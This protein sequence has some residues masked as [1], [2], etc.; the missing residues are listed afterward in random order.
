MKRTITALA[1]VLLLAGCGESGRIFGFERG[2]PDE[3]TVVRNPPLS[4]PPQATLRPPLH[5]DSPSNRDL[6]TNQARTTLLASGGNTTGT[7][8]TLVTD[9]GAEPYDGGALPPPQE[10]SASPWYATPQPQTQTAV[11]D[12][13]TPAAPGGEAN[14]A[15]AGTYAQTTASTTPPIGTPGVPIRYGAQSQPSTGEAALAQ[16]ATAY[17][18]VE[19][20]VRRKVNAES[21]RVA[22]EQEKF[23]HLVLFWLEPEPAGTALDA[24]AE[25]RRLREN[26]AL[27]KPVNAGEAPMIARKKSGISSLF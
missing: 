8:G 27:G 3:F 4:V 9:Q 14:T 7:A 12:P 16:R 19:P 21:A 24:N 13:S 18:G 1:A 11:A 20:N 17:Y 25:S 2:G 10:V 23:L 22:L 6:S 15:V 26:D 5:G